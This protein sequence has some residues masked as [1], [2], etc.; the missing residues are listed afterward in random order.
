MASMRF[1]QHQG[2]PAG[3]GSFRFSGM[4]LR[5]ALLIVE[6]RYQVSM[7]AGDRVMA[8]CAGDGEIRI[9]D[10]CT[11]PACGIYRRAS[12]LMCHDGLAATCSVKAGRFPV[13][14]RCK[15]ALGRTSYSSYVCKLCQTWRQ[16]CRLVGWDVRRPP[17]LT[18]SQQATW[19]C[20]GAHYF[21]AQMQ[22]HVRNPHYYVSKG[23][24]D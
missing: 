16:L 18:V 10:I 4:L 9:H 17:M 21:I 3:H 22:R 19:I 5:S 14:L 12:A 11:A 13:C 6:R 23:C 24:S 2:I 15:A 1:V 8:T 7:C 20:C